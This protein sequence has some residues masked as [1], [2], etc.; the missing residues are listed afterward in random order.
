[1]LD[2]EERRRR[3][4]RPS[5]AARGGMQPDGRLAAAEQPAR[6]PDHDRHHGRA[7]Q[8]HAELGEAAAISG[9]ARAAMA[10]STTPSW[11]PMPPSTTIARIVANLDEGEA[12]GADE[13]LPGGEERAGEAAEHRAERE[14]GELGVGRVDAQRLAG[15]LVLAQRLPGP[16]DRQPAQAQ[17][18]TKLVSSASSQD[19]EVE[20]DDPVLGREL[21][22]EQLVE[23]G[24][25]SGGAARRTASRRSSGAECRRCRWAR[26]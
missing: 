7:E 17:A 11:L 22:A 4:C 8:Q 21:D 19:Q 6:P 20:K 2:L 12:L 23:G 16:A 24:R 5:S 1:M 14:G 26:R 25:P 9:S 15:D 13:A 10:A 18:R 3:S